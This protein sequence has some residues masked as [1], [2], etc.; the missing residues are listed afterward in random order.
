MTELATTRSST[1]DVKV[2]SPEL[3]S[4]LVL[5]GDCSALT[6]EQKI[7]YM[8]YRCD[9]LG[10][11]LAEGPFEFI[12]M[13]GKEVMYA[14]KSCTDAL[15][16]VRSITRTVTGKEKVG[17][18]YIVTVKATDSTGR[19]DESTGA[20]PI[21]NLKGEALANA[22]MK[23]ETKAKRRAV[24]SLCGLGMLDE[25]EL[26]TIPRE[27][28]QS[29]TSSK[30]PIVS[31]VDSTAA[32]HKLGAPL[33][34]EKPKP[35]MDEIFQGDDIPDWGAVEK[36]A[37][38]QNKSVQA[39]DGNKLNFPEFAVN[40]SEVL[41][42]YNGVVI[43]ELEMDDIKKIYEALSSLESKAKKDESKQ[44]LNKLKKQTRDALDLIASQKN[45]I[46]PAA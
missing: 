19:S 33:P 18:V 21:G 30:R 46:A 1:M 44:E 34:E 25:T 45:G 6:P 28:F 41:S 42:A 17:D 36:K 11:D 16:R 5:K 40:Y 12:R 39:E 7:E 2:L 20:V 3:I 26:E 43:T 29:K 37:E 38:E 22:I 10:I 14:K 27:S 15:C 23:A 32:F 8:K 24:I 4:K 9:Q 13:N 35:T 31:I